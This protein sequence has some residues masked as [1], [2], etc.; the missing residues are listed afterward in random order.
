MIYALKRIDAYYEWRIGHIEQ[1]P[2]GTGRA[3]LGILFNSVIPLCLHPGS[4]TSAGAYMRG[5]NA[6]WWCGCMFLGVVIM[7]RR[8]WYYLPF[9]GLLLALGAWKS[10]TGSMETMG[11]IDEWFLV[12]FGVAMIVT[13]LAD[14]F[15]LMHTF[16]S[17]RESP[18][19]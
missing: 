6:E 13:G 17:P 3:V 12:I 4:L 5:F 7:T 11:L 15:Y 14:H 1:R 9:A 10:T 8:R 2:P 19:V 16:P 18:D